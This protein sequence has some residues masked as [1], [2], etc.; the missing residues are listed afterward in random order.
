MGENGVGHG[1]QAISCEAEL[2]LSGSADA[3][4]KKSVSDIPEWSK[5]DHSRC[6]KRA[7]SI[8][9]V[10]GCDVRI[11]IKKCCRWSKWR[12][13]CC[14]RRTGLCG[15]EAAARNAC[16]IDCPQHNTFRKHPLQ[17]TQQPPLHP[18]STYIYAVLFQG[19]L[20]S[21]A[22]PLFEESELFMHLKASAAIFCRRT[23]CVSPSFMKQESNWRILIAT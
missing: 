14:C 22:S 9:P 13:R 7:I 6:G 11:V 4:S 20:H 18:L 5:G 19:C 3:A 8:L 23:K 21:L 15:K 2:W 17:N 10:A 12:R 16:R 1:R